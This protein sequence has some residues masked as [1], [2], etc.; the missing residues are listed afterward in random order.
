MVRIPDPHLG[1][2]A[3][4]TTLGSSLIYHKQA[5]VP[6]SVANGVKQVL[7]IRLHRKGDF[8]KFVL[9]KFIVLSFSRRT[10]D[11]GGEKGRIDT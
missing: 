7:V 5:E 1:R 6:K 3:K 10:K 2:E 11:S 8:I 9:P 4:K